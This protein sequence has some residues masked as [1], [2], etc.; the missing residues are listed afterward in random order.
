MKV[1]SI[2]LLLIQ[3]N[4]I[5]L[6]KI[7]DFKMRIIIVIIFSLFMPFQISGYSFNLNIWSYNDNDVERNIEPTHSER[8]L[9]DNKKSK[10]VYQLITF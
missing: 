5:F 1:K 6:F 9:I 10:Y 8:S 4:K 2:H 7:L 3:R